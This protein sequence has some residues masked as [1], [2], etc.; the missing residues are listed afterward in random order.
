[1][2]RAKVLAFQDFL[3]YNDCVDVLRLPGRPWCQHHKAV[4]QQ[5][6]GKRPS[7]N[8]HQD[9]VYACSGNL[10]RAVCQCSEGLAGFDRTTDSI[11]RKSVSTAWILHATKAMFRPSARRYGKR[12]VAPTNTGDSR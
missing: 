12:K 7:Q 10:A 2:L 6:A 1:M 8:Q 9:I 5:T 11:R 3:N 4:A